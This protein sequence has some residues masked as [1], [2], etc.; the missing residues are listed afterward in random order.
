MPKFVSVFMENCLELF[1]GQSQTATSVIE[2]LIYTVK[3]N[4]ICRICFHVFTQFVALARR[5]LMTYNEKWL[6]IHKIAVKAINEKLIQK[7][8][9]KHS[10]KVSKVC[11]YKFY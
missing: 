3:E 7:V 6:L 10:K 1:S 5:N 2:Y 11:F 8:K 4:A 9:K